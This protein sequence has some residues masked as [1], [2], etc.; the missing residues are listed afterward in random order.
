MSASILKREPFACDAVAKDQTELLAG[1]LADEAYLV[2]GYATTQAKARR[3]QALQKTLAD[4]D[5]RPFTAES[6]EK[7]KRSC[8]VPPSLLAMTL[9]NYAAGIGLVAAIVCLPIL[10]VSAVTLNSSLS[11]YLA[12][13]ILVGGGFLVVSAAIGDRYVIDRTWMMYDLAHYT[14]PVPE[15]ALQTALDIK[16]RHPEVSFYICSLEENRMV[17][18]PFLVMRVPDGGWHRDYYLEVWNEPKFAGTREA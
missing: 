9:V 11:F 4:L 15:F 8:E 14:E 13:A 3:Q 18:D 17:L 10:V 16:K 6:V 2:F 1:D 12:L 7:Y 5:V